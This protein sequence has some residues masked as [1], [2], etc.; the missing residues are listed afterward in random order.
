LFLFSARLWSCFGLRLAGS[1]HNDSN[2]NK[3]ETDE[4][5]KGYPGNDD[6][7]LTRREVTVHEVIRIHKRRDDDPERIVGEEGATEEQQ[8]ET[9]RT[10][11]E[12]HSDDLALPTENFSTTR[13]FDQ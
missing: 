7:V 11:S 1:H 13:P 8:Q 9:D 10:I 2:K 5:R 3:R 12:V 6:G 4:C